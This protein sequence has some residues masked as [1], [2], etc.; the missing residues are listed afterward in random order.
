MSTPAAEAFAKTRKSYPAPTTTRLGS[1]ELD[2]THRCDTGGCGA[3][4][5]VR[6]ES[7]SLAL[8]LLWCSHHYTA[9]EH[10]FG[11]DTHVIT[12]ER[13]FLKAAVRAQANYAN[14]VA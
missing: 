2:L 5:W 9:V 4:A 6:T 1:Q 8:P 13:P 7:Y 12:D 10:H 11:E 3:Q 14:G